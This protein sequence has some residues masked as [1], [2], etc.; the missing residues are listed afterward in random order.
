MSRPRGVTPPETCLGQKP[1]GHVRAGSLEGPGVELSHEV[2]S[3]GD[4]VAPWLTVAGEGEERGEIPPQARVPR[5]QGINLAPFLQVLAFGAGRHGF[6]E[7]RCIEF[8]EQI[9]ERGLRGARGIE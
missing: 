7:G 6:T 9:C 4:S 1:S 2:K 5:P 3:R 8:L